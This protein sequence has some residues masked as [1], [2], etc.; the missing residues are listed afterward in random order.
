MNDETSDDTKAI[1]NQVLREI[2]EV[3]TEISELHKHMRNFDRKL[4]VINKELLEVKSD[5]REI[6]MR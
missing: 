2:L 5:M 3:K 1:W 6:E 4:D